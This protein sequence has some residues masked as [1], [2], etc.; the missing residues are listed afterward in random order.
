[1]ETQNI[2]QPLND[3]ITKYN[4]ICN[5]F[6]YMKLWHFVESVFVNSQRN[7]SDIVLMEL[8]VEI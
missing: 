3:V 8:N 2:Q 5:G 1:M 7:F 6:L 4:S